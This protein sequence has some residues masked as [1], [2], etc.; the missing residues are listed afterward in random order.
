MPSHENGSSVCELEVRLC[1]IDLDFAGE[2]V[3][4]MAGS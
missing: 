3:G 2:E 1:W 4:G